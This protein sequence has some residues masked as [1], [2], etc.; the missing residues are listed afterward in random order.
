MLGVCIC[1][2]AGPASS[3]TATPTSTAP[4][5]LSAP[6]L[7]FSGPKIRLPGGPFQAVTLFLSARPPLQWGVTFRRGNM[8]QQQRGEFG[9]ADARRFL[10]EVFPP[11]VLDLDL[12][13][14]R[15]EFDPPAGDA[16][17]QPG[18]VLRMPFSERICRNG[19]VVSGQA[20]MAFADTAM[21][22]A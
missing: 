4:K 20:M 9:I 8:Q 11:W 14:E 1:A 10:G 18:A 12:S 3:A 15:F 13:V 2:A 16:D 19:G 7:A 5:I 17:W 22:V 21:V 6:L